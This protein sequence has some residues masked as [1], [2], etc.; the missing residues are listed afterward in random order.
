MSLSYPSGEG[1]GSFT[2]QSEY[3]L[4]VCLWVASYRLN[5]ICLALAILSVAGFFCLL[6]HCLLAPVWPVEGHAAICIF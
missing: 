5:A 2:F 6:T 1:M 3:Y 4:H